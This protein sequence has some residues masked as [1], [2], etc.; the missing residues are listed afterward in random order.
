VNL[1][2]DESNNPGTIGGAPEPPQCELLTLIILDQSL[3]NL[4]HSQNFVVSLVQLTDLRTI[5][6]QNIYK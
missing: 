1:V 5:S 2:S 6:R 4:K 3:S